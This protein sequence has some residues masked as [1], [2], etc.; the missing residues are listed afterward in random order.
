L[1]KLSLHFNHDVF[2]W[3][4]R[5]NYDAGNHCLCYFLIIW[6]VINSQAK[7]WVWILYDEDM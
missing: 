3:I 7:E 5:S 2:I 6:M 4:L 1:A